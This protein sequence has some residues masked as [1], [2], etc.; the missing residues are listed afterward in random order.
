M[1]DI[2]SEVESLKNITV[3]EDEYQIEYFIGA[4]WK[5][6]AM[7]TGIEAANAKYSCV[8][9]KCPSDRRHDL[10]TSWSCCDLMKGAQTIEEIQHLA[11]LLNVESISMAVHDNLC[12]PQ[13]LWTMWYLIFLCISDVLINLPILELRRLDGR[14]IQALE[15]EKATHVAT[16]E[17]FLNTKC[18]N[19]F[20][21][22]FAKKPLH[23]N[24]AI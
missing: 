2:R 19:S 8:W 5:S 21:G 10:S 9:C 20:T 22:L 15:R 11:A 6:L 14:K 1:S 7:C 24:G 4:D 16:Y 17:W 3:N 13:F 12:F 18:K 23:Y